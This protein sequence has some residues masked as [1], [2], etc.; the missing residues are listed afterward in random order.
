VRGKY[1][2]MPYISPHPA[3][4]PPSPSWRRVLRR[5]RTNQIFLC[6]APTCNRPSEFVVILV[7]RRGDAVCSPRC[8][9]VTLLQIATVRATRRDRPYVSSQSPTCKRPPEIV[10][11]HA[12]RR[13]PQGLKAQRLR[14]RC[15][16]QHSCIVHPG[17]SRTEPV[18][19]LTTQY[20]K[21]CFIPSSGLRP[22]SP[23][24]RR[25]DFIPSPLGRRCPTGRMRGDFMGSVYSTSLIRA[26]ACS[27][28]YV[29]PSAH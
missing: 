18:R 15:N 22:P 1:W 6:H 16:R 27:S 3:C 5:I 12:F 7:L 2:V 8:N 26:S 4:R 23:L 13:N 19:F 24:G 14:P 11:I 25:H 28:Y 20:L 17:G 10:L 29:C 21:S 9:K